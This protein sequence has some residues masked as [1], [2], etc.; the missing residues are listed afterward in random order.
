MEGFRDDMVALVGSVASMS[1]RSTTLKHVQLSYEWGRDWS[2][3]NDLRWS[4]RKE[5]ELLTQERLRE[6][7][8]NELRGNTSLETLEVGYWRVTRRA[9]HVGGGTD[10]W[11]T[12]YR[13]PC[14]RKLS[15][16]E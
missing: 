3:M 15:N 11:H 4:C 10:E 2:T 5:V 9:Q 1:A 12:S 8:E 7:V 13:G 6:M 16:G 14:L